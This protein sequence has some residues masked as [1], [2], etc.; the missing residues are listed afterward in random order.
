MIG[1]VPVRHPPVNLGAQTAAALYR[2][3][4]CVAQRQ[5]WRNAFH[6]ECQM[7]RW[8]R[9]CRKLH[10][11]QSR[12]QWLCRLLHL[13][14]LRCKDDKVYARHGILDRE[15]LCRLLGILHFRQMTRLLRYMP[16]LG[17]GDASCKHTWGVLA[18]YNFKHPAA[19]ALPRSG[20][21]LSLTTAA[22]ESTPSS[23]CTRAFD[24]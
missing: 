7:H 12:R 15:H 8:R 18:I 9:L 3:A 4:C 1:K 5:E 22:T 10:G 11:A 6:V 2:F 14:Q 17:L 20:T 24:A 13:V 16:M 23:A 21:L 19:H